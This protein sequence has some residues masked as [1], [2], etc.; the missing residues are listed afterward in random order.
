[1][2]KNILII[3]FCLFFAK[4]GIS[5]NSS[6]IG[7]G[8][9][10]GGSFSSEALSV[11]DD[12][13]VIVGNGTTANGSQ[14]FIWTE[15]SGM[16]SLG[17]VNDNSF[18]STY[19]NQVSGDGKIVI[20][21][22]LPVGLSQYDDR[23]GFLWA[24]TC[25]MIKFG[26]LNSSERYRASAVSYDGSVIAGFGGEDAF[27]WTKNDGIKGLGVLAG[28]EQ[29]EISKLSSDGLIG[30][31]CSNSASYDVQEAI[32][33]TEEDGIIGL[34]VL[35][36]TSTS[37][38]NAISPD[39]LVILGTCFVT[40]PQL[41]FYAFRWT[42]ASGMED[43]GSLPQKNI[44]HP[45]GASTDGSVIVGG[46]SDGPI[47][48]EAFIWDSVNGMRDLETVVENEYGLD[49]NGWQLNFA[50]AITPDGKNIVGYGINPSGNKEAFLLKIGNLVSVGKQIQQKEIEIF[51][52]SVNNTLQIENV[53]LSNKYIKY[54]IV[55]L[56]GKALM[57]GNLTA[58][59]INVSNINMGIY[60]LILNVNGKAISKKIIIP[61]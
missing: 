57:E 52:N 56:S 34:G 40:S 18:S 22:G 54:K 8:D 21:S 53:E 60:F 33:W 16:V 49:L 44:M 50:H 59:E 38:C 46:G 7:L 29:S 28:T 19:V 47:N 23:Q 45:G 30:A 14:A 35:P 61:S 25:G 17:N 48:G 15:T 39:G 32:R 55:D 24:D 31:G 20:G 58:N 2:K 6:I 10:S 26:S 41:H 43:L 12:G 4:Y 36:G 51:Q 27:Y 1:M 5:Q 13:S 42:E 37:T 11:S 9:L 3:L